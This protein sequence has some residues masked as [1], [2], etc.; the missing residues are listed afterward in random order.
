MLRSEIIMKPFNDTGR[1]NDDLDNSTSK[2]Y[3][4]ILTNMADQW[5]SGD[6]GSMAVL[7]FQGSS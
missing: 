2:K 1:L 3:G 4:P 7:S 6:L 5:E